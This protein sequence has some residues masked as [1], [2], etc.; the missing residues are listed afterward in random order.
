LAIQQ[1]QQ[2]RRRQRYG[3]SAVEA[4][5]LCDLRRMP[6]WR[7]EIKLR[8]FPLSDSYE[9]LFLL[10]SIP[11]A[12]EIAGAWMV[13]EIELIHFVS[14]IALFQYVKNYNNSNKQI[15]ITS[16]VQI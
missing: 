13:H 3:G 5:A 4:D 8:P 12:I 15:R 9:L 11:A 6:P 16:E 10:L 1:Q 2:Q 7:P 14:I